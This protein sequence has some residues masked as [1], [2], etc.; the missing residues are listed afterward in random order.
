MKN[1]KNAVI[2]S[3]FCIILI[4][5]LVFALFFRT[6]TPI[7]AFYCLENEI[8]EAIK[9]SFDKGAKSIFS[10]KNQKYEYLVL[11]S[12]ISL[13]SQLEE[14]KNVTVVFSYNGNSQESVGKDALKFENS[15]LS[16]MPTS[17]RQVSNN[18][19]PLL[20]NHLEM[21]VLNEVFIKFS[22]SEIASLQKTLEIAESEKQTG[23]F[24]VTMTSI[25]SDDKVLSCFL[26][27]YIESRYGVEEL[28]KINDFL[29]NNQEKV[30]SGEIFENP[31]LEKLEL[32]CKELLALKNDGFLHSSWDEMSF[33][34]VNNFMETKNVSFVFMD[35]YTHRQISYG[36]VKNYSESFF[37]SGRLAD[38]PK[39]RSLIVPAVVATC[40]DVGK[41]DVSLECKKIV[42]NMVS[43]EE[44]AILSRN[45]GFA[46]V[47]S[48]SDTQD[49][50]AY[51]VRLWGASA[52]SLALDM[53]SAFT[54]P[55][56][57]KE[58]FAQLR[59]YL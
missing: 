20:L 24:Y 52:D 17:M 7:I 31:E 49:K 4:F 1:K 59:N 32:V 22:G 34:D 38:F 40:F 51:N 3:I 6:K 2:I 14:M 26:S 5:I 29:A 36:I 57:K 56:Y 9:T 48:F 19:L 21:S 33:D 55:I 54:E 8:V 41:E 15:I 10:N 23:K 53:A 42:E 27:A 11:D 39:G 12:E 37:P 25:G 13:K 50:Q 46:P 45:S 30:T 47:S 28:N 43:L 58:F 16:T 35:L 18:S 44:Q